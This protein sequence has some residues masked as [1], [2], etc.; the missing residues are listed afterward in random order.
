MKINKEI[1]K[2]I[3][4]EEMK[5]LEE[6]DQ[7]AQTSNAS[8]EDFEAQGV[9]A[10]QLAL[11]RVAERLLKDAQFTRA[12]KLVQQN[13][14]AQAQF[15]AQLQSHLFGTTA[16]DITKSATRQRAAA[17]QMNLGDNQ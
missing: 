4:L 6:S 12:I 10:V 3:I 11:G 15:I 2:K 1:L 9:A 5:N 13:E 14:R 17:Q 16:A 8:S 7:Q